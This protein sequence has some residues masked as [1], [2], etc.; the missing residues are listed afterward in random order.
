MTTVAPPPPAPAARSTRALLADRTFGVYFVGNLTSNCGTWLQNIAAAVVVYRLTGSTV[1]VGAVS[2]L[3]FA[4]SLLLSPWAGALGDRVD[5]RMLLLSGQVIAFVPATALAIWTAAV[6]VEGL[7]GPWP[8]FASATLIGI[9][10]AISVPNMQAL[11]PALV[12]EADLEQAIALNSITFNLARAVGPALGALTLSTLGAAAAFGLNALTYVVLI[13]ALL[14]I[15]PRQVHRVEAHG[16]DGSVREGL[17]YVRGEPALFVLLIGVT[18]L[19]FGTDPVNTLAPAMADELGGGDA[20]V[21]WLVSAFGI[22]AATMALT[23]GIVRRRVALGQMGVFGLVVLAGGLFGFAWSPIVAAALVA[24]A[25]AGVGFL[26]ALTGLTTELQRRVPD[27]LLGRV[28]ALWAVAFL[29]SR[30]LAALI[31][32]AAADFLGPRWAA[33]IAGVITLGAAV[34]LRSARRR[35]ALDGGDMPLGSATAEPA[36]VTP[37]ASG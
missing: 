19:G 37:P 33:V 24:L 26:L 18:A 16:A 12:E 7:P 22:G 15:R 5:R 17:R 25:L 20:L 8:V 29:G 4:A 11:V 6:G 21:G 23:I 10:W 32:G 34:W 28:M 9:G 14:L 30:P 35:Y 27:R 31:D 3:Q 13:G 36:A 1:M 2:I